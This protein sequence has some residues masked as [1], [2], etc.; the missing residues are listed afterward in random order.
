[1]SNPDILDISISGGIFSINMLGF[2]NQ[3]NFNNE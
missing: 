1:M 3:I 2:Q